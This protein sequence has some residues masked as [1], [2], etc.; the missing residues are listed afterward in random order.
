MNGLSSFRPECR[1]HDSK[2][3]PTSGQFQGDR[4]AGIEAVSGRSC[5]PAIDPE[6]TQRVLG[7][8]EQSSIAIMDTK[9]V[10]HGVNAST[11]EATTV[12]AMLQWLGV[13]PLYSRARVSDDNVYAESLSAP[14]STGPRSRPRPS[15]GWTR[16]GPGQPNSC[17]GTT[18]ITAT[19]GFA[20]SAPATSC[21][22]WPKPCRPAYAVALIAGPLLGLA[23]EA[24]LATAV[25]ESSAQ[26]VSA[27]INC[28]E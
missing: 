4:A 25:P 1:V 14:P 5:G 20:M 3:L 15:P 11:L 2:R 13:K 21:R 26:S 24:K 10:R 9:P 18:S 12:L 6:R 27:A 17:V 22:P 16:H 8:G 7:R 28:C 19:A 23:G